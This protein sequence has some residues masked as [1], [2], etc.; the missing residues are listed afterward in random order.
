MAR[1]STII[2][3]ALT[4]GLA[5]TLGVVATAPVSAAEQ[6]STYG[7]VVVALSASNVS[8]A[9]A[10]IDVTAYSIG[11]ADVRR[12]AIDLPFDTSTLRY[13]GAA[14][15]LAASA[16][17]GQVELKIDQLNHGDKATSTLRFSAAPGAS[18][19]ANI[20]ARASYTWTSV[21]SGGSGIRNRL[22]LALT[23]AAQP[24]S[25]LAVAGGGDERAVSS[26]E[27]FVA[28]EPVFV[29]ATP[30]SGATQPFVFD[31]SLARIKGKINKNSSDGA[32]TT[33]EWRA[34]DE[35]GAISFSLAAADLAP[36]EYTLVA[37][38]Y[39]TG[40]TLTATIV[41]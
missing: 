14:G 2:R 34:A 15:A 5:L 31:K 4:A 12:I 1:L 13:E 8:A 11:D 16:A 17:A 26:Q 30:R 9:G 33:R 36:G 19:S 27:V 40:L 41:R 29:W 10:E 21:G 20:E 25:I 35:N 7:K 39:W 28:G 24:Q 37:R 22:V 18:A 3:S 32:V 38:G 23:S 6:D